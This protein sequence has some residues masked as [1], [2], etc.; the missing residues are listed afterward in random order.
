MK[1]VTN[2]SLIHF[3]YYQFPCITRIMS[4]NWSFH[5]HLMR[6]EDATV[7]L[8]IWRQMN[9]SAKRSCCRW[10]HV[11]VCTR[12]PRCWVQCLTFQLFTC[13]SQWRFWGLHFGGGE[14]SEVAIIAAGST[15]LYCHSEPPLTSGKSCFIIN[16]SGGHRREGAEFL[17]GR[18]LL[19]LPPLNRPWW[20]ELLSSVIDQSYMFR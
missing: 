3:R 16:F 5:P 7:E 17:L 20:V 19:P 2:S 15:D 11:A 6:T 8:C 14:G 18:G 9:D 12:C 10:H 4:R 1:T 13:Q